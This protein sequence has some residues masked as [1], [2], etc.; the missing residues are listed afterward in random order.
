MPEV[1]AHIQSWG[2][3]VIT[4]PGPI[5]PLA[6]TFSNIYPAVCSYSLSHE[7]HL[8][9]IYN[10]NFNTPLYR[11]NCE[12]GGGLHQS[13]LYRRQPCILESVK[14]SQWISSFTF[15]VD[16]SYHLSKIFRL[17]DPFLPYFSSPSRWHNYRA[18]KL[19]ER[20]TFPIKKALS[21]GTLIIL[22]LKHNYRAIALYVHPSWQAFAKTWW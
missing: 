10:P 3:N 7:R 15:S 5:S 4:Y 9:I 22:G 14:I 13:W 17:V 19:Y 20:P 16:V 8:L 1:T 21:Q 11:V 12:K 6:G 18:V 2:S